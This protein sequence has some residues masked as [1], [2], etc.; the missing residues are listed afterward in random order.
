[1]N[2]KILFYI[3]YHDLVVHKS[4]TI[5]SILGMVIGISS[6][7][8][9][10]SVGR[11]VQK[12]ILLQIQGFGSKTI[13]ILPGKE[14]KGLSDFA[15][16]LYTHS[17]KDKD[18]K[19]LKNKSNVPDIT[20]IAPN[21]FLISKALYQN[22]TTKV[23]VLGTSPWIFDILNITP[24]KGDIFNQEDVR[25]KSSVVVIGSKLKN[26]LFGNSE[27]LGKK[28]RIR[29]RLYRVIGIFSPQGNAMGHDIDNL[30]VMPYTTAKQ[31]L[32]G[33]DYYQEIDIEAKNEKLIPEAK[34]DIEKTLRE[35]HNITNPD[36]DDFHI[37]TQADAA[38][39]VSTITDMLTI[40][41]S[42]IASISIIVSGIGIMNVMF[43][44]VTERTKEIGL[45]KALGATNKNIQNQ[46]L[47]EAVIL[48]LIGGLIGIAVGI[49]LGFISS[50]ILGKI[51]NT[52]QWLFVFP[53]KTTLL[54]VGV[55]VLV[56]IVFGVYPAKKAS[57]LN[58]VE[59]LRY[60]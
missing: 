15:Q 50:I 4:R 31:Y 22:K 5:L 24:E 53:W 20:K 2:L 16:V 38:K 6:V 8:L 47:L 55:S 59:A 44:S 48:T 23:S 25:G 54:A 36:K 60:E 42:A 46:F 43:V 28:I 1:M 40:L 51:F 52:N 39:R 56:G 37:T 58:P 27:A 9:M 11:Y 35:S 13:S 3:A 7:I 32:W 41:L 30:A 17:L 19:A 33:K 12:S 26:N 10:V 49:M 18:V 57:Q 45:R 34:K 14:P 29:K 21:V